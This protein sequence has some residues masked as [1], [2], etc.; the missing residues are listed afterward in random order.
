MTVWDFLSDSTTGPKQGSHL[1]MNQ[2]TF[3]HVGLFLAYSQQRQSNK[4]TFIVYLMCLSEHKSKDFSS[5]PVRPVIQIYTCP[6]IFP[7]ASTY[8]F[9]S[10]IITFII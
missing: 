9:I 1:L 4:K 3:G 5:G 6:A 7:Q 10:F 8:K 2:T